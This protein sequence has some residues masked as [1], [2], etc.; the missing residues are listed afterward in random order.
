MRSKL[1]DV[2]IRNLT[3]TQVAQL[4]L[5]GVRRVAATVPPLQAAWSAANAT[6]RGAEGPLWVALGDSSQLGVGASSLQSC[7]VSLLLQHLQTSSG[8][9]WRV[10]NLA[11]YGAKLADVTEAQVPKLKGLPQACL[12]TV[13]AGANDVFWTHGLRHLLDKLDALLEAL[14]PGTVVGTVPHGWGNKGRRCNF[15]LRSRCKDLGLL[16]AEAGVLPDPRGMVAA[17][18]F[19]PNDAGYRFIAQQMADV[20]PPIHTDLRRCR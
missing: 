15:Y 2:P 7:S 1:A 4:F 19:H 11:V 12:V 6:A 3:P 14:P 18:H 9:P 8:A 17:D 13:G 16:V 5:P 10:L 20:L